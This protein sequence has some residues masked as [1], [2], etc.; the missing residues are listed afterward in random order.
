[1]ASGNVRRLL[2]ML[3]REI[4]ELLGIVEEL[5]IPSAWIGGGYIRN[6]V[7]NHLHGFTASQNDVD[8]LYFDPSLSPAASEH[9]EILVQDG[10][11]AR[12]PEY[13]WSLTN[14]AWSHEYKDDAPYT[15]IFSAVTRFPETCTAVACQ[16]AYPGIRTIA[17]HGLDD[18]FNLVIRPSPGFRRGERLHQMFLDRVYKRTWLETW[19]KLKVVT[20]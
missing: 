8:I 17:P 12:Y 5:D 11:A 3:G 14:Q 2:F 6:R 1:M 9:F 7:W 20:K 4:E 10:L 16:S 15:D 19:P 13:E 18:L